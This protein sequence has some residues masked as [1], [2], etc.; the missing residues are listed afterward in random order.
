MNLAALLAYQGDLD[1][2]RVACELAIQSGHRDAAPRAAVVLG[3]VHARQGDALGARAAYKLAV[4]SGHAEAAPLAFAE[5]Q[6]LG[7]VR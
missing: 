6:K 1:G 5:L 4:D 3:S 7:P 2:A